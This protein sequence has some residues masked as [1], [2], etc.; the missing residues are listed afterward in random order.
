MT[1]PKILSV[2]PKF[3]VHDVAR[4][5]QYY[6]DV[7]GF[8]I[9]NSTGQ[10]PVFGIV[11]RDGRGIQVK[12]GEPRIRRTADEAWD[13]YFEV[14]GIDALHAE[15]VAKGAQLS[16]DP[17]TMPYGMREFDAV[18]PDGYVLCFGEDVG[19]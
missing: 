3:L 6:R 14:R 16:R 18:D 8:Q 12:R 1:T 13:A 19:A 4:S 5:L 9:T 7:C 10:P 15:L 11:E 2:F 17:E